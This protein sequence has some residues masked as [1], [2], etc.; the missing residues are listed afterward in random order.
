MSI[1]LNKSNTHSFFMRLA[2]IQ[3]HKNLGN[4]KENP[5]VGCVIVKKNVLIGAGTTGANGRPHAEIN[6][7]NLAKKKL[8]GSDL[9]VT[10]E[11][12]SH[13]GKTPP[14]VNSIIKNKVRKVFFSINDPDIRSFN[15]SVAILKN[16]KISICKGINFTEANYFYRSYIKSKKNTLPF[17]TCKIAVSKD[18]FTVSKKSKNITNDYSRGRVQLMRSNH[19]CIMTSSNTIIKDNP[20]LTCRIKGLKKMSPSRILLDRKLRIPLNTNILKESSKFP[21]IIFYNYANKDKIKRIKKF[22]VKLFKIPLAEDGYF[23]LKEVLIKAKELGFFRI[24]LESGVK[25]T[26]SFLKHNLVDD[27]KI[28][29]SK[30]NLGKIGKLSIKKFMNLYLKKKK[31]VKERVNLFGETFIS[32]KLK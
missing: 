20:Q 3:A 15:K 27:L 23:D 8:N 11:P 16:K 26:S 10:L 17:V 2:L 25:L 22:K 18:F 4:T 28:F 7:M 31:H 21:T 1:S 32:Y 30:N 6:A 5:S 29:I 13:F 19:D 12:C 14:C 24:F 9:Y